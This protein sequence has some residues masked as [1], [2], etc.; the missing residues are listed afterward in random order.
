MVIIYKER[1]TLCKSCIDKCPWNALVIRDEVLEV[2]GSCNL[3]GNCV[4]ACAF[5]A[6]CI[7][8]NSMVIADA[9]LYKGVAVYIENGK[10]EVGLELLGAG[11]KLVDQLG[12]ILSAIYFGSALNFEVKKFIYQGA[13]RIFLLD[14]P[15]YE[16]YNDELYAQALIRLAGEV[17]PE[18]LL[19]GATMYGVSLAP[20]VAAALNTGLTANCTGLE[21]DREKKILVQTRPAFG[22]DLMASI[23]CAGSRPQMATVR[24]GVMEVVE[25]DYDRVGEIIE[26][27]PEETVARR[28]RVLQKIPMKNLAGAGNSDFIIAVGRGI[29]KKENLKYAEELA[30][31][32]G[33]T[34]GATRPVVDAGWMEHHRLIGLT[35]ETVK[36]R[37]YIA[38]GIS[39]SVQHIAGMSK[40]KVIIAINRDPAA[41]I[42]KLAN[43]GIIGDAAIVLPALIEELKGGAKSVKGA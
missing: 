9:N 17:K 38:C 19:I 23:T 7:E 31:I 13:D 8:K 37:I 11:R 15:L 35:G 16:N 40:S 32:L 28:I 33:A 25:P 41:A 5:E 27:I 10:E 22:G 43:F 24:P 26:V 34:L 42:F 2:G 30:D 18:I 21:I 29:G 12:C 14:S 39:G 6:I 1:C 20:R 36:P 4:S 3:C